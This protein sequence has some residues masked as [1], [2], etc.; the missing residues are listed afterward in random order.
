[1]TINKDDLEWHLNIEKRVSDLDKNRIDINKA[2]SDIHKNYSDMEKN[3]SEM[4]KNLLHDRL[5]RKNIVW[6]E[7]TKLIIF[8]GAGAAL[9]KAIDWIK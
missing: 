6:F 2:L 4:E 1:M 5:T 8:L 3:R 7:A 9:L